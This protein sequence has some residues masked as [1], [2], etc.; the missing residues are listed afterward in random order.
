MRGG[1]GRC[2]VPFNAGKDRRCASLALSFI[3]MP[4]NRIS[5]PGSALHILVGRLVTDRPFRHRFAHGGRDY[6]ATLRFQGVALTRAEI[7]AVIAID[8]HNWTRAAA[9]VVL[10]RQVS[11]PN[12]ETTPQPHARDLTRQQLV[13][14]SGICDG[15]RN[16]DIGI[17]LGISEGAVKA[18][19]QQLFRQFA[20]RRRVQLVRLVVSTLRSADESTARPSTTS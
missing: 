18:T 1:A 10:A 6:L 19:V 16:R 9:Q 13:V 11:R 2:V 4:Q 7:A 3:N 5:L 20:V 17:Q 8:P 15:L 12:A 14:L